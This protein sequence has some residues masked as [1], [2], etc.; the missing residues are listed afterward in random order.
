MPEKTKKR[1]TLPELRQMKERGEPITVLTAYDFQMACLLDNCSIDVLLVGD[2]LGN[3]VY[4][5]ETTLPVTMEMMIA[6]TGAIN[7]GREKA[8]LVADMPFL[9]YQVSPEEA[10][11]NAGRLIKEGGADAVKLEGGLVMAETVRRLTAV[12]IPVMGHIGLRPQAVTVMGGYKIKGRN[13]GEE[14]ALLE[15]ARALE[16]AGAFAVVL[17]GITAE[18]AGR[19]T[20]TLSIPTIGIGA[21]PDCDGQVLV[22]NDLL[23]LSDFKPRF[24]RH[25]ADLKTTAEKA[26][27]EYAKAVK[28][29]SFPAKDEYFRQEEFS[30]DENH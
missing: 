8:F 1:M 6:H 2:S 20:E 5:F 18:V 7:R 13:K 24:V 30:T 22:I 25:F 19:I 9:S 16:T 17:E 28:E 14:E 26:V 21:G 27:N 29:K 15:D 12:D 3:V 23:G 11:K 10:I 4:G